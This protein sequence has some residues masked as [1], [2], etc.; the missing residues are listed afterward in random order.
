ML[1]K[2]AWSHLHENGDCIEVVT[3]L[4]CKDSKVSDS[5][6]KSGEIDSVGNEFCT[7]D[8]NLCHFQ[9]PDIS[10]ADNDLEFFRNE[11]QDD[12]CRDLFDYGWPDIGNFDDVDQ[13]FRNCDS[14]YGQ[15]NGSAADEPSW[16]S[17]PSHAVNATEEPFKLGFRSKFETDPNFSP[18]GHCPVFDD[19]DQNNMSNAVNSWTS[20]IDEASNIGLYSYSSWLDG[21]FQNKRES[22]SKEQG[23]DNDGGE[24][25]KL[26]LSTRA[27]SGSSVTG[28]QVVNKIDM[29]KETNYE[30]PLEGK[31]KERSSEFSNDSV[32]NGPSQ[33][34]KYT[35]SMNSEPLQDI[36]QPKKYWELSTM[37]YLPQPTSYVNVGAHHCPVPRSASTSKSVNKKHLPSELPNQTLNNVQPVMKSPDHHFKS[38]VLLPGE[39]LQKFHHRQQLRSHFS[40][41]SQEETASHAGIFV[42]TAA[43]KQ[44]NHVQDELRGDSEADVTRVECLDSSVVQDSSSCMSSVLSNGVSPEAASFRQLQDVMEQLD[45]RTKLCIR[46]SLYRLARSAEQRHMNNSSKDRIEKRASSM[47]D[48]TNKCMGLTDAETNTNP[49]DRSIAHLLF[50]RPSEPSPGGNGDALSLESHIMVNGCTTNQPEMRDEIE[51]L[52]SVELLISDHQEQ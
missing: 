1:E 35:N 28:S 39:K 26:H 12:E 30:V 52:K 13:M 49:I 34:K 45:I 41:G 47:T 42:E 24:E 14:T 27:T 44:I 46:D 19:N 10:S 21:D 31:R 17:P 5:C 20:D 2:S 50:S 16:F 25:S 51:D 36:H 7:D 37:N 48:E 43:E 4:V 9:L 33:V 38:S 18:D 32:I 23:K 40:G 3:D 29:P 6:F 15:Q 22:A 8:Q 11:Q